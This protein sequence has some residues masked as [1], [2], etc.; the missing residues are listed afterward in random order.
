MIRQATNSDVA[1]LFHIENEVFAQESFAIKKAS[2]YYHVKKSL[3]YVYEVDEQ[4]VGYILW[5]KR[6]HFFRL[7]SLAILK[8]FRNRDIATELLAYSLKNLPKKPLS[9]EVK[10]SNERAIKLYE[11]FDFKVVKVLKGY[12]ENEDGLKM[13]REV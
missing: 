11:K 8:A 3:L 7:Y 1:T 2:F 13:K 9:L 6:E 12:Y 5:L 10:K 4:I